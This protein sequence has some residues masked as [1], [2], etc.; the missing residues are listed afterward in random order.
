VVIAIFENKAY[1]D[2]AGNPRA[3]YLRGLLGRSAVFTEATGVTHPSQPNYLALFS[4]STQGVTD[5]HCPVRL[6]DRP[7]LASQ[8]IAAGRTFA[9]YSE[10]LPSVGYGGCGAG[11]YAAKH[12]P[13]AD[14]NNV[15]ASANQPFTAF[16]IDFGTLPTVAFVVPNLCND[17][18]DC[19]V[20]TGDRWAAAHLDAYLRWA[21]AHNSLLIVTFDE[22]DGSP[23]NR[24][25]S[26]FA[27]ANVK[28]G[29]YAEP[30]THYRVLRTVESFYDLA[31]LGQ[32]AATTPITDV[33]R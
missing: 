8:L 10:D 14:F 25:L 28:A 9:G 16:P 21:D 19:D 32:A 11:R 2:V 20:A 30:V 12:N 26:M 1:Q 27:G 7:N 4:G 6:G 5:D 3:P 24:I 22:N 17:T 33:W 31:P 13:W 29:N 18:H 23:G 15:P